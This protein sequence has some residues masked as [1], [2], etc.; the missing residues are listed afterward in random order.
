MNKKQPT[1]VL[2]NV[3]DI[4]PFYAQAIWKQK[5]KS[6]IVTSQEAISPLPVKP[7]PLMTG[8]RGLQPLVMERSEQR[9]K[10][11]TETEW[12]LVALFKEFH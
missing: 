8:G 11:G 4:S 6:I 1:I 9:I 7:R 12:S 10:N 3:L 5:T 2:K